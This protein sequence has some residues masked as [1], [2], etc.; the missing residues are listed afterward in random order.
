MYKKAVLAIGL[1]AIIASLLSVSGCGL[2]E[3]FFLERGHLKDLED[4]TVVDLNGN[5]DRE[6]KTESD[7]GGKLVLG[8]LEREINELLDLLNQLETVDVSDLEL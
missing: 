2:R 3:R 7:S 6:D 1:A 8:E 4:G 5:E